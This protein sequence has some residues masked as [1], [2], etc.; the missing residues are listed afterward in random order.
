METFDLP[1]SWFYV[2]VYITSANQGEDH[3]FRLNLRIHD[4]SIATKEHFL[5]PPVLLP[6]MAF[7]MPIH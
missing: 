5:V 2:N 6:R 1:N 4:N 7:F 3:F